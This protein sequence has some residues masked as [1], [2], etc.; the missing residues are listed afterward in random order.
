[1]SEC[2]GDVREVDAAG[3]PRVLIDVGRI[4]VVNEIVPE[5]LTKDGPR[6]DCQSRCKCRWSPNVGFAFGERL[7]D[8][9]S[10]H[11]R[12]KI[13]ERDGLKFSSVN[14]DIVL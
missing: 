4:V 3:D 2:P 14:Q 13:W 11:L 6:K 8:G 9:Y 7:I 10:V 12:R 5:C 1:M